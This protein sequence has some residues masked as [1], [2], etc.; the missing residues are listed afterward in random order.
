MVE[1]R[2]PFAL[3][4]ASGM[5]LGHLRRLVL[6][7]TAIP[8]VFT[9]LGGIVVTLVLFLAVN[10]AA[11]LAEPGSGGALLVLP[12]AAFF[13]SLGGGLVGAMVVSMLSW[14]LMD[15]VT[16]YENLRYE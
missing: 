16:R 5:P 8:L 12:D 14:P 9:A 4:R 11:S 13:A 10:A 1:R 7:E 15:A 3:L 2:R 6:F